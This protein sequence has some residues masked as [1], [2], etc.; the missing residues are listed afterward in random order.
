MSTWNYRLENWGTPSNSL[1]LK[2]KINNK[3]FT[4]LTTKKSHSHYYE[5]V[6]PCFRNS[7]MAKSKY[8][9]TLLIPI[10]TA[11][12]KWGLWAQQLMK[13]KFFLLIWRGVGHSEN[14]H[15]GKQLTRDYFMV[16]FKELKQIRAALFYIRVMVSKIYFCSL[17]IS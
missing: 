15:R 17:Q 7:N 4:L 9:E 10:T 3:T 11:Q 13:A 16:F 5:P 8:C 12:Y 6:C 14:T 2:K 1:S